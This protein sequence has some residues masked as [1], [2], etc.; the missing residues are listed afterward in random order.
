MD[1]QQLLQ[2]CKKQNTAAQKCLYDRFAAAMF[3]VCRRYVKKD[4]IAEE[5]VLNGFLKFF[6]SLNVFDYITEVATIAWLKKIMINECLMHLRSS[7]SFLEVAT[8]QLPEVVLD[9]SIINELSAEEIFKVITQLPTGY[10]T[11]FNLSVIE[12]Y[13][14]KEIAQLLG[15]AEGT[16]KSQ[17]SKAKTLLQTLLI[18]NNEAYASRKTK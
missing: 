1:L 13:T 14:H 4:E 16:S 9:E 8:S 7:N 5:M 6:R 17:L 12:G 2:D 15:I 3:L 11:I 10:R 18:Q